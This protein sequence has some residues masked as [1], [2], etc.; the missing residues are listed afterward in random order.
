MAGS[1]EV[2]IG[3]TTRTLEEPRLR[4]SK[5]IGK[6]VQQ[7]FKQVP[8]LEMEI[9]KWSRQWENDTAYKIDR[10]SAK[11]LFG[12]QLQYEEKRD[13]AGNAVVD[14]D[15][16]PV[17]VPKRDE[18][19]EFVY[20]PDH[21]EHVTEEDWQG[22]HNTYTRHQQ[23]SEGALIV[24]MFEVLWDKAEEPL[25]DLFALMLVG[26]GE[27]REAR[28]AGPKAID[29]LLQRERD[30]L[31]DECDVGDLLVL[32]HETY[33]MLKAQIDR[34]KEK[35]GKLRALLP[36]GQQPEE[37]QEETQTESGT[38]GKPESSTSS[39]PEPE[40]DTDGATTTSSSESTPEL[41]AISSS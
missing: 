41:S 36:W 5:L 38:S 27:L 22:S 28:K 10:V 40:A 34:E 18:Q 17:F 6:Q 21:L 3:G 1:V 33:T 24:H 31:D 19:G 9:E 39:S 16:D 29:E 7:L 32:A 25:T 37:P 14:D 26:N 15:G 30:F 13:E 8:N 23:P 12:P 2:R 4:R 11:R 35:A 20:G